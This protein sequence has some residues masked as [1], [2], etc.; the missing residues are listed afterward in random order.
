MNRS[1][2]WRGV[3][4]G[5]LIEIPTIF[6]VASSE[7]TARVFISSWSLTMTAVLTLLVMLGLNVLLRRW[8]PAWVLTRTEMLVVFIMLSSTSVIYGY[9]LIQ[10]LIPSLGGLHFWNTEQNNF[11]SLI[12]PLLPDWALISDEKA[13]KGLFEGYANPPW[14]LWLPRLLS[15]GFFLMAA[16]AATLGLSLLLSRQWIDNERLTFPITALPLEM[17]TDRWPVMRSRLMWLGFAIPAVLESLLA[18]RHYFPVVPAVEMKHMLHP[19]WFPQRPWTVLQPL[20][21]GFTPFIVGLAYVAPT[22]ISFSC[23]FFVVFNMALRLIG[24]VAGWTDAAAGRGGNDF[25]FLNETTTGAFIAFAIS[26][27]WLARRHLASSFRAACGLA[28]QGD[29]DDVGEDERGTYRLAYGLL[30]GGSLGVLTFCVQLGMKPLPVIGLFTIYFLIALTLARLRAEAGPAWAFG[31]DRKPHDLLVWVFGNGSFNPQTLASMSLMTWFFNDVRFATLP[32]YMESL[33][34]GHDIQL[35]RRQL[36]VIIG[37]AT[38][39]AVALGMVAITDQF[40][41]LGASTAKTYGAG[42]GTSQQVGNLATRWLTIVQNPDWTRLPLVC[43]GALVVGVLQMMRQR[44]LW[45]PFH[46]VGYVMAHTGA[47]YS[48]VCHYFIAW[49]VK[50]LILRAGGM[51]LYRQ[52]LPFVIGLILGD[53][54]TQTTWSLVASLMG[55][56]VYQFIS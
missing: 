22:E 26:S 56:E 32:S 48:F 46:P 38:L 9:G 51:K 10:M 47:G 36:V 18:L 15:F 2:P 55:W 41:L 35:S 19:E 43:L 5:L 23:W 31:P 13:L 30:L 11:I 34:V 33:K 28:L 40:Y 20:R 8:R 27:L 16:Y 3:L 45:W 29:R 54:A 1:F 44:V 12:A 4:L 6:W 53:I 24:A 14:L 42:R 37:L 7:V 52:S 39:V 50:T 17:T 25:P 49:L 21:F